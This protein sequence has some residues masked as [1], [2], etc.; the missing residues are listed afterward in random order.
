M[1]ALP[2]LLE[3]GVRFADRGVEVFSSREAAQRA[4]NRCTSVADRGDFGGLLAGA[5]VVRRL[6]TEW[7]DA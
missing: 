7:E 3:F 6:V 1:T 4:A 2:N 5:T